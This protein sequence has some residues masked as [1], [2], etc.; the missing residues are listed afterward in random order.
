MV[1]FLKKIIKSMMAVLVIITTIV[2]PNWEKVDI[3]AEAEQEKELKEN[4]LLSKACCI[5]DGSNGRV[6]YSKNGN[7]P[8]A[9]ASTTK[10][11]T[12]ILA[13]ENCKLDD[14]VKISKE[15]S[16][17]PE[18]KLG[19]KVDEEYKLEDL[20]YA[21]M[22]ESYNDCAYAIAE[23][24]GGNVMN[25]SKMMNDKAKSIG[26]KDTYFITPNGLDAEDAKTFHHT[27]AEDLGIIM[28]YCTWESPMA[29]SFLK[30]TGATSYTFSGKNGSYTV[31]NH[32]RMLGKNGYL[33]GKTGYT[34][35]AGYCYIASW[36]NTGKKLVVALLGCGWPNNKNYK[37]QDTKRLIEYADTK[38]SLLPVA[39]EN[40]HLS[41]EIMDT[42]FG[43][44]TML[45]METKLSDI[46]NCKCLL[47]KKEQVKYDY[48]I[49][50]LELPILCGQ[51][52]GTVT[53]NIEG[54]KKVNVP[55]YAQN[56]VEKWDFSKY[57]YTIMQ[58]CF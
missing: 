45:E 15:A 1:I 20:L 38:Y 25:F 58:M 32:N 29:E 16:D 35:K 55:L 26:C 24:A 4:E 18:V 9:N 10:I 21:M 6:L 46:E 56:S 53:Y 8:M 13:L 41:T 48:K 3:Y 30:I 47:A 52:V 27:T 49:D 33:S 34:S 19:L 17:E 2:N 12:C 57:F 5:I 11:L 39:K 42:H 36:E 28:K 40:V 23:H 54:D 43:K 31:N 7:S 37:W 44:N 51:Q 14:M 22:L 50:E